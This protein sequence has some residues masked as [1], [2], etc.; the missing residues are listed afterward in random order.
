MHT[1][2]AGFVE[3]GEQFEDAVVRETLEETGVLV[4]ADSIT[5]VASQPWPF[6]RSTM[7]AFRATAN[8]DPDEM[9]IQIDTDELVSASWFDKEDVMS[10]AMV[11]GAVM[12]HAI[13]EEAL[14]RDPSLRLLIPPK[15]VVARTLMDEWLEDQ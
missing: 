11:P 15:G 6:P 4:D 3:A 9:P 13:A 10:A 1:A 14:S 12:D 2:L 8:D 7:I 5:Y